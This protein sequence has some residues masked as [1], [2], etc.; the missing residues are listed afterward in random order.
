MFVKLR[1]RAFFVIGY[2][3]S[4][5]CLQL[6][7]GILLGV[8]LKGVYLWLG[9]I[10]A[11]LIIVLIKKKIKAFVMLFLGFLIMSVRVLILDNGEAGISRN[12]LVGEE[13]SAEARISSDVDFESSKARYVVELRSLRR[14]EE[15]V[16]IEGKILIY[17]NRF[18]P[19]KEGEIL[20]VKGSVKDLAVM[21]TDD[22]NYGNYLRNKGIVGVI[23][24][25]NLQSTGQRELGWIKESILFIRERIIKKIKSLLPEP[26][27]GL[28]AGIL[29]GVEAEMPEDFSEALR[30]TGTTHIIAASGY[31]ITVLIGLIDKIF[32]SLKKKIRDWLCI[33]GIWIYVVFLGGS[34]PIVR[35]AIMGT[36]GVWAK[37]RGYEAVPIVSLALSGAILLLLDPQN[38]N[39][40]SFQLSMLSSFGLIYLVPVFEI[41]DFPSIIS[42]I[43]EDLFTTASAVLVTAPVI[44][45]NFGTFS[46]VALAANILVSPFIEVIMFLG[47]VAMLLPQRL[48]PPLLVSMLW[49][50]EEGF[51]RIVERFAAFPFAYVTMKANA[52]VC[53][54]LISFVIIFLI[55]IYYP[56][57]GISKPE[58]E[59]EYLIL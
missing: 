47:S 54:Y 52:E 37:M 50:V 51:V 44:I 21:N 42:G 39:K 9:L 11:I 34:V 30:L 1:K 20:M 58:D 17:A 6:C 36:I 2:F 16:P 23:F 46:F 4:A 7:F 22:F 5:G 32:G 24:R 8:L 29:F 59:L 26:H 38:L 31:N 27:A 14:G 40:I 19:M 10:G 3:L 35:A 15:W 55:L 57:N 33:L 53:G 28:L 48:C 18:P 43:K 13:I 12:D 41:I 49:A 25:G 56:E 45:G